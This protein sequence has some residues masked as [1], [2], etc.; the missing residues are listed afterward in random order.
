MELPAGTTIA[1]SENEC[2]LVHGVF[3]RA[4]GKSNVEIRYVGFGGPGFTNYLLVEVDVSEELGSWQPK[5]EHFVSPR[6]SLLSL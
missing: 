3:C 5:A 4:L 6:P 1:A 2:R